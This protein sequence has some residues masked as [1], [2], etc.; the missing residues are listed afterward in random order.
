MLSV[1]LSQTF[2]HTCGI[3][4]LFLVSYLSTQLFYFYTTWSE[5][6]SAPVSS[7]S[8]SHGKNNFFPVGS[9][10]MDLV[11]MFL[12]PT[13]GKTDSADKRNEE[14]NP[15]VVK[16]RP[17]EVKYGSDWEFAESFQNNKGSLRSFR[18]DFL[19]QREISLLNDF[20]FCLNKP[21]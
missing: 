21:N 12:L 2:K 11:L 4:L 14:M 3:S 15:P 16:T 19:I 17:L 9:S 10:H 8:K 5:S 13:W 7:C 1:S 6:V 20:F 18:E